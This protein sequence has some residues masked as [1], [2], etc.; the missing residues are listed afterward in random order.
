M[1]FTVLKEKPSA[2]DS[3]AAPGADAEEASAEPAEPEATEMT[4]EQWKKEMEAR[5]SKVRFTP[6]AEITT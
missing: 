3:A 6:C 4:L 5:K 2:E 1:S